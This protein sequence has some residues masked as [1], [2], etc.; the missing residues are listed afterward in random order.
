MEG[1]TE[2]GRVSEP[3]VASPAEPL[4]HVGTDGWLFLQGGS[5][6]V[7]SLY[8]RDGG[9]LPDSQLASWRDAIAHRARRFSRLGI[10]WLFVVVPEKLTVYEHRTASPLVDADLAPS[11]RLYEQLADIGLQRHM[12]DLVAPMRLR[13]DDRDLYWRTDSHWSPEGCFLAYKLICERLGVEADAGLLSRP[14]EERSSIMD[15]GGRLDP[16]PWEAVRSYSYLRGARRTA[17]NRVTRY[18]E[19]P[20]Y[21]ELIHVGARARFENPQAPNPQRAMLIGDS[22][23]LPSATRLTGMMAETFRSLEFVWSNSVDWQAIR[24]RRP[25]IV[26]C[27]IAERFLMLQPRDGMSWKLQEWLQA[28]RARRIRAGGG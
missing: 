17:V 22:Y 14:Y 7:A 27:E 26:I 24:W 11:V 6:F 28:R 20:Q 16:M 12:L 8:Q 15:L 1:I 4:V 18:L 25:D 3:P 13:R 9:Q 5:N 23:A 10:D 2:D 21:K 19:D